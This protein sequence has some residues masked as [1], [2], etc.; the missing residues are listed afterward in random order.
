MLIINVIIKYCTAIYKNY[1]LCYKFKVFSKY[2]L[3][4]VNFC[5]FLI[6]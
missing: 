3:L 6:N 4:I 5:I 2:R 1:M